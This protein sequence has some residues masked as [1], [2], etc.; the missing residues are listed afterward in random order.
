VISSIETYGDEEED[1]KQTLIQIQEDAKRKAE[2][3]LVLFIERSCILKYR[4]HINPFF[5]QD[6]SIILSLQKHYRCFFI[7]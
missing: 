1:N 3:R 4:F 6:N 5:Y 2:Q 7:A